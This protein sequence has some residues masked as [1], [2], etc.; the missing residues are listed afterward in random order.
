MIITADLLTFASDKIA[1]ACD[2]SGAT[3]AVALDISKVSDRF[4]MLVL[5]TNL[6]LNEFRVIYLALFRLFSVIDGFEWL[7]MGSLHKNIQLMPEF[8]KTPF[9]V[10]HFPYH[11]LMTFLVLSIKLPS[12]LMILLSTQGAIRHLICGNH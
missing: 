8:L 6:S 1:R 2:M 3:R 9:L 12:M 11:K 4:E 7:W 5:F 10:L